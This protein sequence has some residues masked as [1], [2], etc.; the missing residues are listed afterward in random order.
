MKQ[1]FDISRFRIKMSRNPSAQPNSLVSKYNSAEVGRCRGLQN[2]NAKGFKKSKW[3][4]GDPRATYCKPHGIAVS[5]P[6]MFYV[7][8]REALC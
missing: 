2:S 5:D 7:R 8:L 4:E 1:L 3:K 6:P